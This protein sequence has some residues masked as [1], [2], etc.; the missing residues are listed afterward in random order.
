LGGEVGKKYILQADSGKADYMLVRESKKGRDI[1]SSFSF[2]F[3][4]FHG[5]LSPSFNESLIS[6]FRC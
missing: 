2:F 4:S 3:A 5:G 1:I 6:R